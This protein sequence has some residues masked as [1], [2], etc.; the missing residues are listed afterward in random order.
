MP[1]LRDAILQ[2]I[3]EWPDRAPEKLQANATKVIVIMRWIPDQEARD[4]LSALVQIANEPQVIENDIKLWVLDLVDSSREDLR[5][6]LAASGVTYTQVQLPAN[7]LTADMD[8]NVGFVPNVLRSQ[9]VSESVKGFRTTHTIEFR[10]SRIQASRGSPPIYLSVQ[11]DESESPNC[12]YVVDHQSGYSQTSNGF[13]A[14]RS[15]KWLPLS[16]VIG[17]ILAYP[18]GFGGALVLKGWERFAKSG[19]QSEKD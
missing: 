6:D 19:E 2:V 14:S 4:T 17:T 3:K 9:K 11:F 8:I 13:N 15:I 18:I 7:L 16:I 12:V 1:A 10:T 5:A